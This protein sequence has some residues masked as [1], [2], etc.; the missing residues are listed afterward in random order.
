MSDSEVGVVPLSRSRLEQIISNV[1]DCA[2]H[3][4]RDLGPGLLESV[5]QAILAG[6]LRKRGILVAEQVSTPFTYD[7]MTFNQGLRVDL[8]VERCV[9][10]EI[11]SCEALLKVHSK[12]VLTYLRLLKLPVGLLVNFGSASFKEGCE[13]IAN[14]SV[15]PGTDASWSADP[16]SS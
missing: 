5:Y 14:F 2:Y 13:R 10:V 15:S 4:H 16:E 3:I 8:L 6:S 1:V 9:V 12:Q 11:K 7:G